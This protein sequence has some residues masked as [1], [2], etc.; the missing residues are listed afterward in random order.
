MSAFHRPPARRTS[1]LALSGTL[2]LSSLILAS[3]PG[4]AA[5]GG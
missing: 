3:A 5:G 4:M 1:L 2:A